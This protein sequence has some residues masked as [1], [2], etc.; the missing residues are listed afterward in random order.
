MLKQGVAAYLGELSESSGF[1]MI[2]IYTEF[3]LRFRHVK[4]QVLDSLMS[5]GDM[6]C[7]DWVGMMACWHFMQQSNGKVCS[8]MFGFNG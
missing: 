6:S 1:H 3:L 8:G 4:S 5:T 2:Q 7:H